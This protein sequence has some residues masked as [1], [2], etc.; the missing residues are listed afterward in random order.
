MD[1]ENVAQI[2][3]EFYSDVNSVARCTGKWLEPE[4]VMS[5]KQGSEG[6]TLLSHMQVE[7]SVC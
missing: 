1:K 5:S 3:K 4:N 2:H 7:A 6:G